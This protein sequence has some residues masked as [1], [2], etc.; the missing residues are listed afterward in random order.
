[1]NFPVLNQDC[2]QTHFMP[3]QFHFLMISA[4]RMTDDI[5]SSVFRFESLLT[6]LAIGNISVLV[7]LPITP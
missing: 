4:I 6:P 3:I 2:L 7:K 1:M 5:L